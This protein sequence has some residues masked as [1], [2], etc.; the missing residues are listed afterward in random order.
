MSLSAPLRTR[1]VALLVLVVGGSILGLAVW[2]RPDTRGFGTHQQLGFAPCGMLLTTGLPCPTCGMTT[3]FSCTMHGL[4][5]R[6]IWAQPAGFV[7]AL[8]TVAAV[9][10]AGWTL[11]AGRPPRWPGRPISPF[12]LFSSVLGLLLF[13]WAWK[14]FV[15]LATGELPVHRVPL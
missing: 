10:V 15:G 14:L 5:I 13:G 11:I 4:W 9:L 2:L 6:A 1:L 3:A 8:L 7:I 12:L